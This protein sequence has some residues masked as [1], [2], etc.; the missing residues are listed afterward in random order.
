MNEFNLTVNG[1]LK[2]NFP[3]QFNTTSSSLTI[4]EKLLNSL[5]KITEKCKP[6]ENVPSKKQT[7]IVN[8]CAGPGAGKST[9]SAG[10]FYN[11][12]N[13][14][15]NAELVS[16]FAKDLTWENRSKT[17]NDQI[18]IF[19]KQYHRI[20]RLL[21]QVDVIVTDSPLIL[22]PIYDPAKRV[23]LKKLVFEEVSKMNNLNIFIMRKKKFV[24]H[25]RS[26][27][28]SEAIEL[29]SKIRNILTEFGAGYMAVDGDDS[30]LQIIISEILRRLK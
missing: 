2:K 29:D 22:T 1:I 27:T 4:S 9:M 14:S 13:K 21:N 10:I 15:I 5:Q 17:L 3:S 28:E 25:G 26:Q 6:P 8:L 7:L 20:F 11:L 23:T 18:Y 24:T 12:K 30:G 16:E 19:G